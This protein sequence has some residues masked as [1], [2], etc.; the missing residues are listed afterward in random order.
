MDI[1]DAKLYNSLAEWWPVMSDP[2]DYYEEAM[3]YKS[4]LLNS[5]PHIKNVIELGSGGGNNASHMKKFFTMTLVDIS[6]GMIEVSKKL[7]PE[8]EHFIG[9]MRMFRMNKV[10]DAV[11]IHDAIAYITTRDDLRR[12]LATVDTLCKNNGRILL[13]PDHFKETFKPLTSHGGH[14]KGN[15][16]FRYLEWTTDPDPEDTEYN[17]DFV[18]MMRTG[19]GALRIEE[20]HHVLGLFPEN[21]WLSLCREAGFKAEVVPIEHS[22]LEPGSYKGILGKKY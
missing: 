22:E 6:P 11:F 1:K 16:S 18:Y 3:Q 4:I 5:D 10:F 14:D 2:A 12:V 15:Q 9:D 17:V 20:D 7:N 8:C 21:T 13:T 19:D